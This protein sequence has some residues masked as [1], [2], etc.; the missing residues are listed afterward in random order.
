MHTTEDQ[1]IRRSIRGDQAAYGQ[2]IGRYQDFVFSLCWRVLR[3]REEAEEAAQDAFLKAY[4]KLPSFRRESQFSTWLYTLTYRTALDQA[5]KRGDRL[6]SLD[7]QEHG[8]QLPAQKSQGADHK[9]RQQE[10]AEALEALLR[11]LPKQECTLLSLYY[12]QEQSVKEIAQ[13]T[14]LSVTNVKTKLFRGREKLRKQLGAHANDLRTQF[15][16]E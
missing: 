16:E 7:D 10:Q 1:L 13:I 8:V 12:L 11:R 2:L 5:R 15:Y 3:Q 9:L 4:D 14:G 6:I